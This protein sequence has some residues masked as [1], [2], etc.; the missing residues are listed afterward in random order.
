MI[1]CN[2]CRRRQRRLRRLLRCVGRLRCV[3]ACGCRVRRPRAHA[4]RSRRAGRRLVRGWRRTH[5]CISIHVRARHLLSLCSIRN[6]CW[7]LLGSITMTTSR[8]PPPHQ[9]RDD[10]VAQTMRCHYTQMTCAPLDYTTT[11]TGVLVDRADCVWRNDNHL[12]DRC[13]RFFV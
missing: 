6:G 10:D 4:F 11:V 9:S 2:A 8:R 7:A 1:V 12:A 5:Y 3:Y 13:V